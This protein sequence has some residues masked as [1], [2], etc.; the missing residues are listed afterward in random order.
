MNNNT[1][2][3]AKYGF[4]KGF[5][6][7]KH[8]NVANLLE[9]QRLLN[10]DS[11]L[12][13]VNASTWSEIAKNDLLQRFRRINIPMARRLATTLNHVESTLEPVACEVFDSNIDLAPTHLDPKKYMYGLDYECECTLYIVEHLAKKL[14]AFMETKEPFKHFYIQGFGLT[15]DGKITV[16]YSVSQ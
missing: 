8:E 9:N 2:K 14:N 7:D 4:M 13:A 1:A 16:S 11:R 12:D 10:E 3:W 6:P 5:S 15:D